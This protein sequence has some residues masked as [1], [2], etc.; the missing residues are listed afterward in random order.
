MSEAKPTLY[1]LMGLPGSGKT[2]LGKHL[3]AITKA[4]RLSSDDY[5]LLIFPE[6]SFS[7][8]EHDNLYG[9]IDH[10]AEHLLGAGL[11]VIYDAN[12]NRRIHRNEKYELA[13]KYGAEVKLFWVQTAEEL[14]KKRRVNEQD[15]RLIPEGET[16]EKMFDR[17]A[18]VFEEPGTDEEYTAI[19][20][21]KITRDYVSSALSSK[22]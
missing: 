9:L 18:I 22:N 5:R 21:T 8:Q 12:L 14:A 7:Q 10:N 16:S 2:T 20:G 4:V 19:D 3:Q 15:E 11:S 17:I 13:K 1:L 6:P